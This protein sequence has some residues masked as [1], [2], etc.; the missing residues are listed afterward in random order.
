MN[1]I[2]DWLAHYG[3]LVILGITLIFAFIFIRRGDK[4]QELT[5]ELS[6]LT[7]KR[8]LDK[9]TQEADKDEEAFKDKLGEYNRLK[10]EYERLS[11]SNSGSKP[12]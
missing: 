5:N 12:S 3:T 8:K 7:I 11:Q 6:L 4:I 2:K 9:L 1:K 10:S